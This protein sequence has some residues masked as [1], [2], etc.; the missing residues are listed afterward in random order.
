MKLLHVTCFTHVKQ[1]I[2]AEIISL[3]YR[4]VSIINIINIK[5]TSL[6]TKQKKETR[7]E[8]KGL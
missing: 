1:L 8:K 7:F 6:S 3:L 4:L 5:D 2:F